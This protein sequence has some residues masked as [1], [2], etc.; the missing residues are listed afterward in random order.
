MNDNSSMRFGNTCLKISIDVLLRSIIVSPGCLIN[1]GIFRHL[2][3]V[4]VK[5]S[6]STRSGADLRCGRTAG[7]HSK[8][9]S[10][11]LINIGILRW[12]YITLLQIKVIMYV[13]TSDS[14]IKDRPSRII[15]SCFRI[16]HILSRH[17][18]KAQKMIISS[19]LKKRTV[20]Q[21]Q[22]DCRKFFLSHKTKNIC[23]AGT[24]QTP[25]IGRICSAV[26]PAVLRYDF[27]ISFDRIGKISLKWQ[28]GISE[29]FSIQ[30]LHFLKRS[31]SR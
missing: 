12:I 15:L 8:S 17:G 11:F 23:S 20:S 24:K 25:G 4:N 16:I 6:R 2:V 14:R 18:A 21:R 22:R 19:P 7:R 29:I 28:H 3:D 26:F 27:L 9:T 30:T 10:E 31:I 13:I 5:S 1:H